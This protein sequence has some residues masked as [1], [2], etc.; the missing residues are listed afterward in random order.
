[1]R[2][3][4]SFCLRSL[5]TTASGQLRTHGPLTDRCPGSG[6]PPRSSAT[7][8]AS[9]TVPPPAPTSTMASSLSASPLS[10]PPSLAPIPKNRVLRHIPKSA[11]QQCSTKLTTVLRDVVSSNSIEAWNKHFLF[12]PR[13]LRLPKHS[14]ITHSLASLVKQQLQDDL[15]PSAISPSTSR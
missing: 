13:C 14:K 11:R 5:C 2:T 15:A 3:K 7:S 8:R 9:S 1:M 10:V 4:C 12:A 6:K